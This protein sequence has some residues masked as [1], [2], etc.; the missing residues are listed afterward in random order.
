MVPSLLCSNFIL[1]TYNRQ[2]METNKGY[3]TLA[4]LLRKKLHLLNAHILHLMFTMVGTIDAGKEVVGIPNVAAFRD[5]LCDLDLWHDAPS[6]L[7]KSL[8][9]HFVELI[10]DTGIQKQSLMRSYSFGGRRCSVLG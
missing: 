4:M 3:Q 10:A 5:I 1:L 8:F 6:E 9:E 2:Q 7:E